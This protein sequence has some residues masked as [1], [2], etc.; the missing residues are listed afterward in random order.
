[1]T[2]KTIA[3]VLGKDVPRNGLTR[4]ARVAEAYRAFRDGGCSRDDADII[5]ADLAMHSGYFHVSARET[6][7]HER[8]FD[9]GARS[10][11]AR[12]MFMMNLPWDQLQDLQRALT[13]VT[14]LYTQE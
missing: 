6:A 9:D 12:M 10:V 2:F 5:I 7:P 11:F 1:M 4:E 8:A 3:D 13:T 14:P